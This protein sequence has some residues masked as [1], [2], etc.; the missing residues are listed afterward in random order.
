[1]SF[2]GRR[3]IGRGLAALG[4]F[5]LLHAPAF[6]DTQTQLQATAEDGF[7]RLVLEFPGKLDLPGYKI[8]YDNGV[9]A[10]ALDTPIALAMPDMAATLP[11]YLT[12]G[13]VDPDGRGVRFG[14]R[15]AVTIHSMEAGDKLFID[16][17]PPSWQ[18]LPPALPPE[19]VAELA[20]RARDAAIRAEQQR[21][22]DAARAL[23]PQASVAVGRNPT[24]MR[25]EFDWSV[26][27]K[28]TFT[29]DGNDASILFEWPVPVDLYQLKA[30]LPAEIAS[31]RNNVTADGSSIALTLADGVEARFYSE[32][33][34]R[35]VFDIDLTSAEIDANRTTAETAA[36][37]AEAEAAA[38]AEAA[39]KAA[40][41]AAQAGV[42]D[43][44]L[45]MANEYVPGETITPAVDA[46][47][48]T[49]RVSF[50]FERDTPAAVFR[51]GDTLWMLFDTRTGI[52]Q[53][54][55]SDALNEIASAF[56]VIPAG[57]AQMVRIDLSTQKLATLSS[58]G[59]SWV[60]SIGDV[61]LNATQPIELRRERDQN[62]QF[63]M[64]AAL[65]KP[66]RLHSFRDP[67]VGDVLDV[68]TAFGPAQG[69]V[70]DLAYVDFDALGSVQGLVLRRDNEELQ[71]SLVD[72]H[73]LIQAPGGLTLSDQDGP[74][75]LDA[76]QGGEVRD[77]FVDLAG[78]KE[79]N[80][81]VFAK[82]V[83]TLSD[84]AAS[85]EGRAREVA[86]LSL[87]QFYVGNQYAQEAI[88]VL[89]LLNRD[90]KTDELKKKAR[91][92]TAIA[93]VLAVRP[94]EAIEILSGPGLS[95]EVDAVLWRT[96]ARAADQDF[97]GAR[98]D[99]LASEGVVDGYP[100]WVQQKF[101]FAGAR[102]A[103]ETTDYSLA[104]R[105]LL[106][107]DF[108]QLSPEDVTL[109]QVLQGRIEEGLGETEQALGTFGQVITTDVRPTRAEAVYRTL[110]MLRDAGRVDVTKATETLAAEAMLWRG[111]PLEV[112]MEKLLAELYF[113]HKDY[114]SGFEVARR[115][116]QHNP[117]SRAVTEL[118]QETSAQFADL[119]LNGAA[120]QLG[121]LEALS[122]Y[123]DFRQLTPAGAKGDE[124]IRNLARRLV[125]VDLLGQ[126]A[127]LLQYQIDNRLSGAA[128]AQ[129][130][131]DLALIRIAD[132]NPEAALRALNQT[133][134][135]NLAPT[136]ER[137]RRILEAR[138]LV[139]ADRPELALDLISHVDGRDADLL[140][141]DGFWRAK[142]YAAAADMMEK[143]YSGDSDRVLGPTARMNVVK[144][145]VG[146]LLANDTIGLSRL[147][148]KF[149]GRMAQSAEWM[150]FDYLTGKQ[151]AVQD[152]GFKAAAKAVAGLD[153]I[154]AF[155]EAYR[156]IYPVD[157]ALAP[158]QSGKP[159]AA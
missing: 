145:A 77:S 85:K 92:T 1:M 147:R 58:A 46:M 22:A 106:M 17:L 124:M 97:V 9:L 68:V 99:A 70:R 31:V 134:M 94:R 78:L 35:Y 155:L 36:K 90:I 156:Q 109:Y 44:S 25:V 112:D 126:A 50:P 66:Y 13:R 42:L 24:F 72:D 56:T 8:N 125:K 154:T 108:A 150:M 45:A 98:V 65:G 83:E 34:S 10:L 139:D 74:R 128:K 86:R 158:A 138:A 19:I 121:E 105:Y 119:F 131:T 16:M 123:Y 39:Q 26:D 101:L 53:P 11:E 120:D 51:R 118:V 153:S 3:A 54:T 73:A 79:D 135:A 69:V 47:A 40:D 84:V 55:Q 14:L 43:A 2:R 28:A 27:T 149:S 110:L 104:Q 143:I 63:Q 137:E 30:Q 59:R 116:V 60:L 82:R 113:A 7:G 141:V 102:A 107:L 132:H 89:R 142:N 129:V 157:P 115:T 103:V 133:R 12:V 62:G 88:G 38:A 20:Q 76:R 6:A 93:D 23:N 127:D 4:W 81:A 71:V 100:V 32:S 29:Q 37:M 151:A 61:L 67:V 95:D 33:G 117:D 146:Y 57:E 80:P 5:A 122:L 64:T 148:E 15:G 48:G 49:V 21:I 114:R 41:A 96:I 18:G 159:S 144:S 91:L 111:N 52:N 130:A 75:V 140:R 136:L 87:A 152:E